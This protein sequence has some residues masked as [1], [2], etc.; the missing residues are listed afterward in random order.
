M[1]DFGKFKFIREFGNDGEKV[2]FTINGQATIDDMCEA[3]ER[4]LKATGYCIDGMTVELVETYE[5]D[6]SHCDHAHN[7]HE[8]TQFE[9]E[10]VADLQQSRRLNDVTPE[11]WNEVNRK[12]TIP[13]PNYP[14]WDVIFSP[15][16]DEKK[17]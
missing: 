12:Y 14:N 13:Y 8:H 3:F 6:H 1:Y 5:D 11:E 10:S 9:H 2:E 16:K 7:E 17:T 15:E 4:F